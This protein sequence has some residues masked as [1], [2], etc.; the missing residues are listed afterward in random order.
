MDRDADRPCLISDGTRDSLSDPPCR[1]GRELITT[2]PFELVDGLHQTNIAF[3]DQIKELQ[4]AIRVFLCDR[5]NETQIG[6]D[7]FAFRL[8]CLSLADDDVLK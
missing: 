6:L 8:I 2:T 4:S 1:I 3:L 5:N 7:Q